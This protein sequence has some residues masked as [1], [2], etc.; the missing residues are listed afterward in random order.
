M[1]IIILGLL[2]GALTTIAPLLQ[3]IKTIRTKQTHDLSLGM[4]TAQTAGGML[5]LVYAIVLRDIPVFSANA[6]TLLCALTIL[7]LMVRGRTNHPVPR[8]GG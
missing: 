6:L 7:S 3:A 1:L 2:A 8:K 5:W 4:W